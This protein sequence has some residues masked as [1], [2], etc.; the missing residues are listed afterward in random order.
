VTAA[1]IGRNLAMAS[2]SRKLAV[3][4]PAYNA[5]HGIDKSIQS[6]LRQTYEDFDFIITDNCSTD[7]TFAIINS[8]TDPRIIPRQN[9]SNLGPAG[10]RSGM[11]AY[12]INRGYEYM[13]L[14]DADDI[15]YPRRLEKQMNILESSPSLSACGGSVLMEENGATWIAPE[16]PQ[17]V[18]AEAIF[19]N[20]I[21][22]STA[23]LRVADMARTGIAW[24][25]EFVLCEDYHF[26]YQF[27]FEHHLKA[28]NTGDVEGV[29]VYSPQGLSHGPGQGLAR[30]EEKDAV[31]KQLILGCVGIDARY[32]DV[33]RFMRIG[34]RRSDTPADPDGFLTVGT[35]LLNVDGE[36]HVNSM[37][38]RNKLE[39]RA[40][41][42]LMAIDSL[43]IRQRYRLFKAFI[44][45][46]NF[47]REEVAY[48][49][50]KFRDGRLQRLSPRLAHGL[51][52][53]FR[54]LARV[55]GRR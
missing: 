53:A 24:D 14:M 40:R 9:D 50:R 25:H 19:A 34:L 51:S 49:L 33:F 36:D 44:P 37:I 43:G 10:N 3:C 17:E 28:A 16:E 13:A 52:R 45:Q 26:W 29:Y 39:E 4:M 48:R 38:V 18:I 54:G 32:E 46:A 23:L 5:A 30:Q 7:D 2:R 6:I 35:G 15:V 8:Y 22:T 41:W 21:P 42:Y 55:I 31:V 47:Y 11:L 20:P 27:L 12:C 1:E